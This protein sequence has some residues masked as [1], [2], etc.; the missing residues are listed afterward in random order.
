[1]TSVKD[2]IILLTN[3]KLTNCRGGPR[4]RPY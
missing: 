1:M 4:V 2:V 3:L